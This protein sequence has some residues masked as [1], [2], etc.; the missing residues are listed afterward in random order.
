MFDCSGM[1]LTEA[2]TSAVN[3]HISKARD[4]NRPTAQTQRTNSTKLNE[5]FDCLPE[6]HYAIR[7][8]GNGGAQACVDT[9][10]RIA[11]PAESDRLIVAPERKQ[12]F[13][14]TSCCSLNHRARGSSDMPGA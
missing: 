9:I 8:S 10:P 11:L 3:P 6:S 12:T 13:T 2:V 1:A 7:L 5:P 14:P 4:S